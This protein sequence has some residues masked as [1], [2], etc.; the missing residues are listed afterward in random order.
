MSEEEQ[1]Q[2]SQEP[3]AR[4][5]PES[6]AA[7]LST[8]DSASG[9]T[10]QAPA[11]QSA[12]TL[13]GG[14]PDSQ[15][16]AGAQPAPSQASGAGEPDARGRAGLRFAGLVLLLNLVIPLFVPDLYPFSTMPMFS[17]SPERIS[18]VRVFGPQGEELNPYL[19][20]LNTEN[21][22]NP[23]PRI[24]VVFPAS[25]DSTEALDWAGVEP[26]VQGQL[27]AL[28]LEFVDVE[29]VVF[30]PKPGTQTVAP[31]L[32]ERRRIQRP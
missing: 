3:A 23:A 19:F 28:G 6:A 15:E 14:E 20:R 9:R 16:S 27:V 12:P 13:A 22:A 25:F 11:E 21:F 31:V 18:R 32:V 5:S 24:G 10:P 1:V 7:P 4:D 30:G 29:H 8:R 2:G 17:S 26:V